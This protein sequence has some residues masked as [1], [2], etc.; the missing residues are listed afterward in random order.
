L[1]DGT[2]SVAAFDES[3]YRDPSIRP[4]MNKIH[5]HINDEVN[6]LYPGVVAMKVKATTRDGRIISS[7]PRDPLGHTNNPMKDQDVRDKFTR[8]VEPVYG[9]EKTARVLDR[10]WNIKEATRTDMG[11]ALS[12][13]DVK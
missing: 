4:L 8:T 7:F 6:A 11:E 13:L 3:A 9:T 10:W 5:I 1:V 12:L 2:I